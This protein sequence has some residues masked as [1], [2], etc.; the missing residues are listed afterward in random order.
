MTFDELWR[1]NL[2]GEDPVIS[3]LDSQAEASFFRDPPFAE[4]GFEDLDETEMNIFLE[5]LEG[6]LLIDDPGE[7]GA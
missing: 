2:P 7:R 3:P 4:S 6:T 1:R 5:R